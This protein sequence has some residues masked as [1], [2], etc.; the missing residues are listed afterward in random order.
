MLLA[1]LSRRRALA[2]PA[3]LA[4]AKELSA[5]RS[6]VAKA[7]KVTEVS[8]ALRRLV[9]TSGIHPPAEMD[10]FLAE[11]DAY[12]FAPGGA[13]RVLDEPMRARALAL[14]DQLLKGNNR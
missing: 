3:E 7:G 10:S 13:S 8:D 9:S 4:R 14:A 11:C 1:L 12:A 5:Q 2:D 6:A